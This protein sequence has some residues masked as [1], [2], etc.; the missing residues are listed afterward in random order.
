MNKNYMVTNDTLY[1]ML[2]KRIDLLDINTLKDLLD[3]C[4]NKIEEQENSMKSKI[5]ENLLLK[6]VIFILMESLGLK[7]FGDKKR[8][9]KYWLEAENNFSNLSKNQYEKLEKVFSKL[10]LLKD[11][12]KKG[13][14]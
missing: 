5:D 8:Q 13:N 2:D 1:K 11:I 10:E 14:E 4:K 3:L 6:D 9:H 12:M 7:L